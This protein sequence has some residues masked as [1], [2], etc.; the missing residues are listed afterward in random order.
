MRLFHRTKR[1]YNFNYNPRNHLYGATVRGDDGN[2]VMLI[3]SIH[4]TKTIVRD[5]LKRTIKGKLVEVA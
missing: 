5:V 4:K 1:Y 3:P 2:M